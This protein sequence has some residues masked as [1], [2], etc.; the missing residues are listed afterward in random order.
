MTHRTYRRKAWRQPDVSS[1]ELLEHAEPGGR[2]GGTTGVWGH[3]LHTR[4]YVDKVS[5]P[6]EQHWGRGQARVPPRHCLP[7]DCKAKEPLS[8]PAPQPCLR[9]PQ[10]QSQK[11]SRPV[12]ARQGLPAARGLSWLL[13]APAP[14][15]PS[16]LAGVGQGRR[17]TIPSALPDTP[18]PPGH[19]WEK[20]WSLCSAHTPPGL[21][22]TPPGLPYK[23][24]TELGLRSVGGL[25]Q[26]VREQTWACVVWAQTPH[27]AL[28]LGP[29]SSESSGRSLAAKSEARVQIQLCPL[30]RDPMQMG[31]PPSPAGC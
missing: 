30:P 19:R 13:K 14:H 8:P 1:D 11:S 24:E 4:A 16:S 28:P 17:G 18:D 20:I 10:G 27:C 6:R 15:G 25:S 31:P 2:P 9:G 5:E 21:P 3:G 7:Q 26:L 23:R 12:P 29:A 22:A